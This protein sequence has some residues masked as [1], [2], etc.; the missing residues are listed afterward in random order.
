MTLDPNLE[1]HLFNPLTKVRIGLPP[2]S[3]MP[4]HDENVEDTQWFMKIDKVYVLIN[5]NNDGFLIMALIIGQ[6]RKLHSLCKTWR[7]KMDINHNSMETLQI[8]A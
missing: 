7:S 5:D 1:L 4:N 2:Q 6:F 8:C 3:A